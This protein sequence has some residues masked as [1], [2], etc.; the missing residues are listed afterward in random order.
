[1]FAGMCAFALAWWVIFLRIRP[2]DAP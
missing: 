1:V 2:E